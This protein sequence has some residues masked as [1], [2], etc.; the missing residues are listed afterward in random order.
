MFLSNLG[1]VILACS[2]RDPLFDLSVFDAAQGVTHFF[3]PDLVVSS[4]FDT[5][6]FE[7]IDPHIRLF[8]FRRQGCPAETDCEQHRSDTEKHRSIVF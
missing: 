5:L 4:V 8:N 7:V 1:D 3:P 2:G 6:I